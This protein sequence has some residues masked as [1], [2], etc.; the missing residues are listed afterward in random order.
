MPESIRHRVGIRAT[1]AEVREAVATA[2]GVAGWW[3][4]EVRQ[5]SPDSFAVYFGRPDP[6]AVMRVRGEEGRVV[7]DCLR[8]PAEW[9][10][11]TLTFE[12]KP[13]ADETVVLF[14]HAGWRAPVE[15]MHHCSTRWGYFLLSLKRSLETGV[16]N[17]YP[18][19]EPASVT[20]R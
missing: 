12:L 13:S 14:T 1:A 17:A 3:T 11:T 20:W 15:F 16:S 8:G 5:P 19:D 6:A 7:W 18:N 4:D 2:T 10:D 9:V